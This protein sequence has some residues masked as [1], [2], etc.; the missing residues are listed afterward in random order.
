VK[1]R[2]VE[3]IDAPIGSDQIRV[4][5]CPSCYL[6][7][8]V[9]TLLYENLT[10]RLFGAPGIWDFKQCPNPSC[11]LIW[12]DP[13]PTETDV[14]KAYKNYYTHETQPAST[15]QN[16]LERAKA[17]LTRVYEFG[18][19]FT[20]VYAERR[21]LELMYLGGLPPG[22]VLEV[23]CGDGHTL[24]QLRARGWDVQG[25][26]VDEH[27]T[28]QARRTFGVPVFCSRLDEAR[29]LDQEFDA[30]VMNHVI[31]HVH[32]PLALLRESKRILKR[33]GHLVSITPNTK[34]WGHARFGACWIGMD[35]P[36][37]LLLFSRNTLEQMARTCGFHEVKTWTTA[38]RS[39]WT[40]G[41][42]L[43]IERGEAV[44]NTLP[45]ITRAVRQ[46]VLHAEALMAHRRD[47]DAGDEC[48]LSARG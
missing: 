18:W 16:G 24:A 7:G 31:E 4:R 37:H 19:R 1:Y 11:S 5:S 46:A 6:C 14:G 20:P 3:E 33:G 25:L 21:E 8:A 15:E 42:S 36:R 10:D 38:A 28:A 17:A 34:G 41:G 29:F 26:E 13:M 22:R 9:G 27:A 40:V 45:L 2:S 12:L 47:P 48:V 23:G 30:V 44:R 39:V 35:R 43:R 32:D